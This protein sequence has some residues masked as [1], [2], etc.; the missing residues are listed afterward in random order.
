M[1]ADEDGLALLTLHVRV[2]GRGHGGL[3]GLALALDQVPLER[4]PG[5]LA[6][7]HPHVQAQHAL[8]DVLVLLLLLLLE[9]P[10]HGGLEDLSETSVCK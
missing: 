10:A 3:G 1:G 7:T 5:N 2:Q 4:N 9:S 8:K 6:C